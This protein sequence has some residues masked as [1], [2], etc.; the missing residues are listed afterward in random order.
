M[1][2]IV[3]TYRPKPMT[4][5][6]AAGFFAIG[7]FPLTNSAL[8]NDRGL[9]INGLISLPTDQATIFLWCLNAACVVLVLLGVLGA[10]R[11]LTSKATIRLTDIALIIPGNLYNPRVKTIRYSDI[12][13]LSTMSV[14]SQLF[15]YVH[16]KQ[17]KT[18]IARSMME[19]KAKYE[20][21]LKQLVA[22]INVA[23]MARTEG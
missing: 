9:L 13:N 14:R 3:Y 10:V 15:L 4:M 2:D 22:R 1:S 16:H 20:D 12:T 11:G 19:S 21:M 7:L 8:H 17:G 5:L 18:S 6:L 23:N